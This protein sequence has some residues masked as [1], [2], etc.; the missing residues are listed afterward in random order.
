[1]WAGIDVN[2]WI[3]AG[4]YLALVLPLKALARPA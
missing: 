4:I 1:M 2:F 3:A